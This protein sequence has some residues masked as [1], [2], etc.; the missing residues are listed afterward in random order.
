VRGTKATV[1]LAD[2]MLVLI[3]TF[4]PDLELKYNKFYIGLAKDDKSNNFAVFRPQKNSFRVDIYIKSSP[5]VDR[6]LDEAGIE[7]M[8]YDKRW[9]SYRLRLTKTDIKE[10]SGLLLKLLKLAYGI[11][12]DSEISAM[13]AKI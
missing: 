13:K 11:D 2:E 12:A 6:Q 5:D 9:G 4:A 7:V 10:H 1:A 8:Y 3:N